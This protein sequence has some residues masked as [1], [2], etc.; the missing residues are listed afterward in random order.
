MNTLI[1][2]PSHL[3]SVGKKL[4]S[5]VAL[6]L[7]LGIQKASATF[8]VIGT[9][10]LSG[11][12]TEYPTPYGGSKK[13]MGAQYIYTKLELLG[14]GL[15]KGCW[16]DALG[17]KVT[18]TNGAGLHTDLKF[19]V[20]LLVPSITT[21]PTTVFF[22]PSVLVNN[23]L[24]ARENRVPTAGWNDFGFSEPLCWDGESAI[25]V[26]TCFWNGI[27][28][29]NASVEMT[30]FP[31]AIMSHTA[32]SSASADPGMCD[33]GGSTGTP[34]G[35]SFL[36]G[37][38]SPQCRPNI[39][40]NVIDKGCTGK[41]EAG[42]AIASVGRFCIQ[43]LD[44][45]I[46]MLK[47]YTLDTGLSF[48]WQRTTDLGLPW[49]NMG[50]A[51]TTEVAAR[52]KQTERTY[53]RCVV[54][55]VASGLKDTSMYVEIL[56]TPPFECD[57]PSFG[58]NNTQEKI[59][60]VNLSTLTN[61]TPC[62]LGAGLYQDYTT[63]LPPAELEPDN[64]YTINIRVGS[65]DPANRSRAI[66]VFI[67][68]NHNSI[69]EVSEMIYAN[70]YSASQ[71]NPQ[72]ASG[73][74]TVP[75][76][77]KKGLT[78]MRIVYAAAPDL[79]SISA[80]GGNDFGETQDYA[81]NIL[82]FGAPTVDGRLVVCQYDSVVMNA[83]SPADTPVVFRW[84][85]PGGFTGVGPKI[86][87]VD[88][89][90]SLS[91]T[92]Y[93]TVT[94][95][96]RTSSEREVE[97]VVHPKPPIPNVL[98]KE[99]CQYESDAQLKT[100]GVNVIW[101]NVPIGGFGSTTAPTMITHTP[102]EATYYLTQTVN[103]CVSDRGEVTARVY[104]KPPPPIV[105]SPVTYCQLQDPSL[106][107][108]GNELKWYLDSV[109]GVPSTISPIPPVGAPDE[110]YYYVSQTIN[111]CE[112]DRVKLTVIVYAQ[113]NGIVLQTKKFVCQYDT[114]SFI[115]FGNASPSFNYKWWSENNELVSGGGQGPVVFR[116]MNPGDHIVNLYVNNDN[117]ATFKLADTITVRP[118]PDAD[119]AEIADGCLDLPVVVTMDTATPYVTNYEW[120]WAGGVLD[121]AASNGGPYGVSWSTPGVK[122]IKLV[123]TARECRSLPIYEDVMIH[124]QPYA[125]ITSISKITNYG[126]DTTI[127]SGKICARDT[128]MFTAFNDVAQ[129]YKFQWSP[130]FYF[131]DK[132]NDTVYDR[133]RV[134]AMVKVTVT[135]MFGCKAADSV[136]VNAEA[137]CEMA[138]PN[139]FTPNDDGLND[140]FRPIRDGRQD[141]IVF[142]I[143]NRWGNVVFESASTDGNGWDGKFAGRP[144]DMGVYN[145]Y[146]KY[147][148]LDGVIYE[149]K[150]D[151]TLIR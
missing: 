117:C 150:G 128:L 59:L 74:F 94:S 75:V 3:K 25:V 64:S 148:C 127:M 23:R 56:Q 41:P 98:N 115:Y 147:R 93:V 151:V 109:G 73:S 78:A 62:A 145:Y 107:A 67:D 43:D 125:K 15:T 126:A 60:R 37:I 55:C 24:R 68:Y 21:M 114:A 9:G 72:N 143:V 10:V 16:I 32:V 81:I 4:L 71:P 124:G 14:A 77:A 26:S 116:F 18:N 79:S 132:T 17:F 27:D 22:T 86:T 69:Y 11:T 102:N 44:S 6:L 54:T 106:V 146:I 96:G 61:T 2:K 50:P 130:D 105:V 65:C 149:Q 129:E 80:C 91:G 30:S 34:V 110:I 90:P 89:D 38:D 53:Y 83:H 111:G 95:G 122:T 39:R 137:C 48:Q 133:M 29:K 57:C 131:Q 140:L 51:K 70:T 13:G 113:P 88:A 12:E 123:V 1:S 99:M 92:Y 139:S 49:T 20:G 135:D 7:C 47:D 31:G 58:R 52:A 46:L 136:Y 144:E 35:G 66:K 85:G 141:I 40:F 33:F 36:K 42:S 104:L 8:Y 134:P 19:T 119:I 84:R 108:K 120:D 112:S 87:F 103:G 76:T 82:P 101:Y 138:F 121:Y 28:Y 118:A 142:R 100:D 97:V 5:V 63:A 45:I